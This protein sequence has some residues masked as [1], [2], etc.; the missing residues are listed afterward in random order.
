MERMCA[1]EE[2]EVEE[3]LSKRDWIVSRAVGPSGLWASEC[4]ARTAALARARSS[5]DRGGA[6]AA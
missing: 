1:T 5:L 6:V 2:S 3:M 4:T